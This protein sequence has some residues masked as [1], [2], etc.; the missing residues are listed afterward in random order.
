MHIY[1][2]VYDAIFSIEKLSLFQVAQRV[3]QGTDLAVADVD[4][5]SAPPKPMSTPAAL[6]TYLLLMCAESSGFLSK[7]DDRAE[8]SI[9]FSPQSAL[10]LVKRLTVEQHILDKYG[11]YSLRIYRLLSLRIMLEEKQA[12]Q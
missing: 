8:L 11:E 9:A 4:L 10:S 3:P 12:R 1:D 7:S 5:P 2:S 6:K